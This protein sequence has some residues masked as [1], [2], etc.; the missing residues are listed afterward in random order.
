MKKDEQLQADIIAELKSDSRIRGGEIGVIVRDGGMTLTGDVDRLF[1]K[2]A[3]AQR[4]PSSKVSPRRARSHSTVRS[5]RITSESS[6][7]MP[8][9]RRKASLKSSTISR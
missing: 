3:A 4:I 7:R 8:Y 1:Q 5:A 9:V 2:H 6:S